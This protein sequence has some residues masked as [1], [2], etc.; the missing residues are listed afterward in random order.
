MKLGQGMGSAN[1]VGPV[2]QGPFV[3]AA[4]APG[5]GMGSANAF[6]PASAG[7]LIVA[8]AA[9]GQGKGSANTVRP[10]SAGQVIVTAAAVGLGMG[11]ANTVGPARMGRTPIQ[12]I[13]G[14][15]VTQQDTDCELTGFP[16]R[17]DSIFPSSTSKRYSKG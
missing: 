14:S 5:Q 8:A 7:Q 6:G 15:G 13:S 10:A 9:L 4:A 17:F 2:S 3:V 11:S 12:F 1:A 16:P